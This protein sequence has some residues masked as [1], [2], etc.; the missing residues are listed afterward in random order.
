MYHFLLS[1]KA[2]CLMG[3]K[4]RG[5]VLDTKRAC[6]V[7]IH[8]TKHAFLTFAGTRLSCQPCNTKSN[9]GRWSHVN[10]KSVHRK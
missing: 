3:L 2:P 10:A 1:G 4:V 9:Q 7:S 5:E 8:A 6:L